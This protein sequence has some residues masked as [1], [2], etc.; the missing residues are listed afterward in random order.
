MTRSPR[1]SGLLTT[2][3]IVSDQNT[4]LIYSQQFNGNAEWATDDDFL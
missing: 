2:M 1:L 3:R 4:F